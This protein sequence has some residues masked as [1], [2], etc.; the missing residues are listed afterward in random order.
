MLTETHALA[1]LPLFTL[2]GFILSESNIQVI[3]KHTEQ[4]NALLKNYT[5]KDVKRYKKEGLKVSQF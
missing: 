2:T 3:L 4:F 5:E 1:A